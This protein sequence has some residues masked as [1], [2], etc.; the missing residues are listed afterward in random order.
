[1]STVKPS[2][3]A[4]AIDVNSKSVGVTSK[5]SNQASDKPPL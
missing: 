3:P 5:S 1:M 2:L 4:T